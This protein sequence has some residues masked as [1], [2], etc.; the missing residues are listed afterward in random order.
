VHRQSSIMCLRFHQNAH[1]QARMSTPI[2]ATAAAADR[3]MM[4]SARRQPCGPSIFSSVIGY[5]TSMAKRRR[6]S[7][8]KTVKGKRIVSQRQVAKGLRRG[9]PDRHREVHRVLHRQGS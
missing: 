1:C 6:K 4:A 5:Y 3:A 2:P 8:V 7:Q 9:V